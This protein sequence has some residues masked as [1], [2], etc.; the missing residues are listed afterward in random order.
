MNKII[1]CRWTRDGYYNQT[2][3][4]EKKFKEIKEICIDNNFDF[5]TLEHQITSY[6]EE[7]IIYAD[8]DTLNFTEEIYEN[9]FENFEDETNLE[10]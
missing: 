6:G 10:W 3:E 8:E 9:D 2:N 4:I 1:I 7:Y 5:P